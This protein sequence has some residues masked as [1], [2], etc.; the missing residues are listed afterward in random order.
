MKMK[1]LT[2]K[3]KQTDD[4]VWE[5]IMAHE[6]ML[7]SIYLLVIGIVIGMGMM[8]SIHFFADHSI[9]IKVEEK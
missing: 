2:G 5:W 6:T 1:T 3:L 7:A 9:S 4:S 8:E